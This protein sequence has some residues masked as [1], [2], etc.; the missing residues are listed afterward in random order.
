MTAVF[1][2]IATSKLATETKFTD[3]DIDASE[4]LRNEVRHW[5]GTYNGNF[6]FVLDI[7]FRYGQTGRVSTSQLRG[8]ANCMLADFRRK[9]TAKKTEAAAAGRN[10]SAISEMFANITGL[11]FP[12]VR[13]ATE[14]GFELVLKLCGPASKNPGAVNIVSR[15]KTVFSATFGYQQQWFGA[16]LPDGT[17]RIGAKMTD[18]IVSTLEAFNAD[19]VGYAKVYG[20]RFGNCCFCGKEIITNESLAVGYGPVCADNYGLPWGE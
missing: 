12:K 20:Q 11:R 2:S 6:D 18:A 3:A 15:E 9:E 5:L 13:L 10:F 8:V 16:I 14:D 4:A 7:Q 19:P 17:L 1:D